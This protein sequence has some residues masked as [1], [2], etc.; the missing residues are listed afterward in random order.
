MPGMRIIALDRAIGWFD[1]D[2]ATRKGR[3][4]A[5]VFG[6]Q[7]HVRRMLLRLLQRAEVSAVS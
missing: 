4:L 2:E 6:G 5:V 1:V 7:D 3:I